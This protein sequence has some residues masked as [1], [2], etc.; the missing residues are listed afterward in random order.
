M[1]SASSPAFTPPDTGE[2]ALFT[3]L[4][5]TSLFLDAL[6]HEC[7]EPFGLS[8]TDYSV[9]RVLRLTGPPHRL[10]PRQLADAVICTSG[11]MT[12]IIDRL[13]RGDLV[14]RLPDP[15]DRRSV[16]VGLTRK[17][18]RVSDKAS[19]AYV[20][21]RLRILRQ[22]TRSEISDIDSGLQR[23]LAVLESDHQGDTA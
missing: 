13:A 16:S 20:D 9:L 8:F 4:A 21:G 3:H 17:G 15:D 12:K 19:Q 10:A 5:R 22:L 18:I 14:E 11:G 7:L 6:Q 2:L 23:L 1:A